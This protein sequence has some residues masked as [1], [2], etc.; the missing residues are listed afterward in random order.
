MVSQG[1]VVRA[2]DKGS[3]KNKSNTGNGESSI[4]NAFHLLEEVKTE[5]K[6]ITWTSKEELQLYTKVVVSGTL[7]F[8]LSVFTADL[9]IRTVLDTINFVLS[10]LA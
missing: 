7:I 9:M 6:R 2:K 10:L 3:K 4:R 5:F 1:A 8:G